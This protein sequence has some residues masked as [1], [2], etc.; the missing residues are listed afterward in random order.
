MDLD[1]IELINLPNELV[2][3]SNLV[4]MIDGEEKT[5][6]LKGSKKDAID[7]LKSEIEKGVNIYFKVS[8]SIKDFLEKRKN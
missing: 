7:F 3:C 5:L 2:M 1:K 8:D 4:A 6:L